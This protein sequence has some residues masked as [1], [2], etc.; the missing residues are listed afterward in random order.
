MTDKKQIKIDIELLRRIANYY[1]FPLTAFFAPLEVFKGKR[2]DN[3]HKK[4]KKFKKRIEKFLE[5]I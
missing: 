1:E 5:E 4:I 2:R 3:L